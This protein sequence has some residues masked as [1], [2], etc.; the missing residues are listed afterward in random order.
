MIILNRQILYGVIRRVKK[1]DKL[2]QTICVNEYYYHLNTA[3]L[4]EGKIP[5]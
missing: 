3:V 4:R 1:W 5:G 2:I